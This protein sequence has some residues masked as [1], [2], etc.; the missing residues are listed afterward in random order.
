MRIAAVILY[1]FVIAPVRIDLFFYAA[2]KKLPHGA[3]GIRLWGFSRILHYHVE[4]N[5]QNIELVIHQKHIPLKKSK[6]QK[7]KASLPHSQ[8]ENLIQLF[9]LRLYA[10]IGL[11]DAAHTAIFCGTLNAI[12]GILP[13]VNAQIYP[14]YQSEG[15]SVAFHCIAEFRLGNLILAFLKI[16]I[17]YAVRILS[18]GMIHGNHQGSKNQFSH[19]DGP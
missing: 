5:D 9:Q 11:L 18:G 14:D 12:G 2:T 16:G 6:P 13:H 17:A 8:L 10:K 7:K 1:L 4:K 19:A 15:D 3:I